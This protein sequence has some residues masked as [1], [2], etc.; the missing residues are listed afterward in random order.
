MT[1]RGFT[2]LETMI[3]LFVTALA[4]L[5]VQMGYQWLNNNQQQRN[6]EQLDWY[7][8]LGIIEGGRYRFDLDHVD[9]DEVFV[10]SKTE[11]QDHIIRFRPNKHEIM[12]TGLHGGDVPLMQN[13]ASC[14]F[15]EKA[16]YLNIQLTTSIKPRSD[17]LTIVGATKETD[18]VV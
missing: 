12:L 18:T 13:I 4:L 1:R 2:L 6:S 8:F 3:A 15:T 11:D 5:T 10:H 16:D 14:Q 9:G 7:G 17:G